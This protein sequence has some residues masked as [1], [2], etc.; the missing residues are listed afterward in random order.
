MSSATAFSRICSRGVSS[1]QRTTGSISGRNRTVSGPTFASSAVAGVIARRAS[2]GPSPAP[3]P[4]RGGRLQELTPRK[5]IAHRSTSLDGVCEFG[6]CR[7]RIGTAVGR[8]FRES[9]AFL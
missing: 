8:R 5:S 3:S 2:Q 4:S 6:G 7:L 1:I 9:S